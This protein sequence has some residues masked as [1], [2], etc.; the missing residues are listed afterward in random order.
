VPGCPLE[1]LAR[2]ATRKERQDADPVTY[3]C[4]A[5]E[6]S[7]AS[8]PLGNFDLS[9]YVR[10]LR[11][12]NVRFLQ[13]A[14]VAVRAFVGMVGRRL[15]LMSHVPLRRSPLMERLPHRPDPAPDATRPDFNLRPGDWVEVRSPDE[16]APTLNE[17][18]LTRGLTFDPEM[19]PYCGGRYRVKDR[20]ERIIDERN[21]QMIEIKSDCLILDGVVCSGEHSVGH[22]FCPRAI[23]P[24][25]REN[26]VRPVD[27]TER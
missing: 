25:W 20:V 13:L 19:I 15:R 5:T 9:Q 24:Y 6:A 12:G 21:G 23:Y 11:S 27:Q 18:G 1:A 10:E 14:R 26:W 17:R 2:K 4:Q 8:E 16:I 3:R 7:R 22:W